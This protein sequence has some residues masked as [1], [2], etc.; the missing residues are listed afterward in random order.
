M[1]FVDDDGVVGAQK[2]VGLGFG[3]QNAVGHQLDMGIARSV[4]VKAHFIAHNAAD[5]A[6]Q[7]FGNTLGHRTC[8]QTARLRV[9][10]QPRHPA[11]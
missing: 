1:R 2:A 8:S 9:P 7:L 6:V 11:P 4:V 5:V 10:N 3:Q